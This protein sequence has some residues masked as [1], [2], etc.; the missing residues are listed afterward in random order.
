MTASAEK[1]LGLN[2][3]GMA[4]ALMAIDNMGT[5]SKYAKTDLD[6]SG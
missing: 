6:T 1:N 4:K 5:P 2:F 3:T